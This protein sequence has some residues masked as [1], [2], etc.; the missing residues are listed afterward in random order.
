[1]LADGGVCFSKVKIGTLCSFKIKTGLVRDPRAAFPSD[2]VWDVPA[3]L[4][5]A[6][7]LRNLGFLRCTAFLASCHQPLAGCRSPP[8]SAR[9]RLGFLVVQVLLIQHQIYS[10]SHL[11]VFYSSF[12]VSLLL[13]CPLG[14]L[15][16]PDTDEKWVSEYIFST[17]STL[18]F[19]HQW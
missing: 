11:W 4:L 5:F 2:P 18:S 15:W 17:F 9:C 8:G 7:P 1:M 14:Y 13:L 12:P 3:L 10:S 6:V 16:V 19:V